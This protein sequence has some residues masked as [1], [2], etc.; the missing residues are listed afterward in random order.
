MVFLTLGLAVSCA[1]VHSDAALL[2]LLFAWVLAVFA[3]PSAG[4]FA[5]EALYSVRP[6]EE[7]QGQVRAVWQN[8]GYRW[9]EVSRKERELWRGLPW[10]E[11]REKMYREYDSIMDEARRE[12]AKLSEARRQELMGQVRFARALSWLSPASCFEAAA[13]AFLGTDYASHLRFLDAGRRYGEDLH[14]FLRKAFRERMKLEDL[15]RNV[16]EWP[17][18]APPPREQ[19]T[20]QLRRVW[21]EMLVLALLNVFLFMIA[22]AFFLR[23]DPT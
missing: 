22:H 1:T 7:V 12:I 3:V 18:F 2:W 21:P 8:S 14:E 6:E 19:A 11:R 5:A 13:T 20:G 17:P 16:K 4:V 10:A 15:K 23:Y 9:G